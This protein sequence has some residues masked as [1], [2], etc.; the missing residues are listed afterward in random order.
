MGFLKKFYT[1]FSKSSAL[2]DLSLI[3]RRVESLYQIL[4]QSETPNVYVD[5]AKDFCQMLSSLYNLL[6]TFEFCKHL[7]FT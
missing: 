1:C 7:A 3:L 5:G 6:S 2:I 4:F